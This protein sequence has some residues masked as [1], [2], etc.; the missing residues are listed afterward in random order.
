MQSQSF[1]DDRATTERVAGTASPLPGHIPLPPNTQGYGEGSS[2]TPLRQPDPAWSRPAGEGPA[3]GS[4]AQASLSVMA[5]N[6]VAMA[7]SRSHFRQEGTFPRALL[8]PHILGDFLAMVRWVGRFFL[9]GP[10]RASGRG[11]RLHGS[12]D[13]PTPGTCLCS[14]GRSQ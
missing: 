5:R 2:L 7:I 11:L 12:Q 9:Q 1:P 14:Q 6:P 13:L 3:G 4:P 10:P 8:H